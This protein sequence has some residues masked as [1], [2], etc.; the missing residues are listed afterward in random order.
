M[1]ALS[2]NL[3][4]KEMVID[5]LRRKLLSEQRT[6]GQL[7]DEKVLLKV[8]ESETLS[9]SLLTQNEALRLQHAEQLKEGD[10]AVR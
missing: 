9:E 7:L 6:N 4:H 1:T 5:E 3:Q 10:I 2:S 8:T